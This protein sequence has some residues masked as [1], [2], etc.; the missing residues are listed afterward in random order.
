[1]DQ[2]L[3]TCLK[4]ISDK[5]NL[6]ST[7]LTELM[8]KK[9]TRPAIDFFQTEPGEGLRKKIQKKLLEKA[10]GFDNREFLMNLD[11]STSEEVEKVMKFKNEI[12]LFLKNEIGIEILDWYQNIS[13]IQNSMFIIMRC[14]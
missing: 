12:M 9:L 6:V 2:L 8:G 3:R 4:D 11:F 13:P 10:E 5:S 1:M 7:R 14:I